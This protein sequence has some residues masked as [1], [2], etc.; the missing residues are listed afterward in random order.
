MRALREC[1]R[2]FARGNITPPRLGL[3]TTRMLGGAELARRVQTRHIDLLRL[4]PPPLAALS[5][6]TRKASRM[7]TPKVMA[8]PIARCVCVWRVR[9]CAVLRGAE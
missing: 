4:K 6:L 8:K 3:A 9:A 5:T 7:P 2:Y 1:R